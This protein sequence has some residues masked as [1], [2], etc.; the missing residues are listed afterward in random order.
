MIED[1]LEDHPG[2][3]RNARAKAVALAHVQEAVRGRSSAVRHLSIQNHL[4]ARRVDEQ[5]HA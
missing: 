3:A 5:G 2:E 1:G 4:K